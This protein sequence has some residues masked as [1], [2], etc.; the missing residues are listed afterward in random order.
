MTR[1]LHRWACVLLCTLLTSIGLQAEESSQ[2]SS[3]TS[4]AL[5]TVGTGVITMTTTKAVGEKI[6]LEIW[7]GNVT[8][9][10]VKEP[11]SRGSAPYTLTGQTVII[12]GNV[13]KFNGWNNKLTNLVFL[14]T[15]NAVS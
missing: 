13:T 12:R 10:G 9:E 8:I 1:R 6:T 14:E 5:R 4:D 11:F 15:S 7:G 2:P 3:T